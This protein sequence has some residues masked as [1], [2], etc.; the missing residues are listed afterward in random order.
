[1]SQ[2][3]NT[4]ADLEMSLPNGLHDARLRMISV[5][6]LDR[7]A[8][9]EA[10]VDISTTDIQTPF[11][12]RCL[13]TMRGLVFFVVS[14]PGFLEAYVTTEGP[15]IDSGPLEALPKVPPDLPWPL[16]QGASGSY[17]FVMEWNSFIYFAASKFELE[18]LDL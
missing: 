1:M 3:W 7:R 17:I 6:Y 10:S 8:S 13:L 12:R 11:Y 16:P 9:V 14:P 15:Q 5:D 2:T 4:L 18:W